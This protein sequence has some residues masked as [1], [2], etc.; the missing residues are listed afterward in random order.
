[1]K[2][3]HIFILILA[4]IAAPVLHAQKKKNKGGGNNKGDINI[5]INLD[6]GKGDKDKD[7]DHDD[8]DRD[9]DGKHKGD[10]NN[11]GHS[12]NGWHNKGNHKYKNNDI[13]WFFGTG[14][15]Y[16]CKGKNRKQRIVIYD[17]VVVRL[18][19]NIGFMFGLLGDIRINLDNKKAKLGPERYKKIKIEIDL[20]DNELKIIEIKKQKIKLRLAKL[21]KEKD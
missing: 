15:I 2:K 11:D 1:M 14:D 3:L 10:H 5:N 18:G 19:T 13:I 4:F 7:K 16:N 21:N 17:N 8:D 6:Q 12:D 9:H 20:L